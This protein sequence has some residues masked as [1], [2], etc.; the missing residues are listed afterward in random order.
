MDEQKRMRELVDKLNE[1]A[2]HYYV[3]EKPIMSDYDYDMMYDELV[4][5]EEDTGVVLPDSPTLR[6]GGDVL[7]GFKKVEHK[8]RLYSLNKCN[9]LG[10]IE[11]FVQDVSSVVP[12]PTFTVEYKFDGLRII[13]EYNDGKLLR[14]ST[15]GDGFVGEDVTEQVKTIKSVPLSIEY[16]AN[17]NQS[18]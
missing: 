11:K 13:A 1:L 15:R 4:A 16:K 10:G 2:Y 14:A 5:L 3:L 9:D 7:T 6:V 17:K 18:V 12:S 8:Y